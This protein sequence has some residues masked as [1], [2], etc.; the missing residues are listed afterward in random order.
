ML[1]VH[2]GMIDAAHEQAQ[3]CARLDPGNG[4][5]RSLLERIDRARLTERAN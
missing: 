4:D 1:L 3:V 2:Q 5:Y